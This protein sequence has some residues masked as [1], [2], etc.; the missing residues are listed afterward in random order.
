MKVF[1]FI[2]WLGPMERLLSLL[3]LF[4][5]SRHLL[6]LQVEACDIALR[7]HR[8]E[9]PR[10]GPWSQKTPSSFPFDSIQSHL[11]ELLPVAH[12]IRERPVF[13]RDEVELRALRDAKGRVGF[14]EAH[15]RGRG[16][17]GRGRRRRCSRRGTTA[18]DDEGADVDAGPQPPLEGQHGCKLVRRIVLAASMVDGRERRVYTTRGKERSSENGRK[19]EVRFR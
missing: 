9:R 6:T 8:K 14:G 2:L 10:L 13:R 5:L 11:G 1:I 19:E 3:A 12:C 7:Q 16:L 18:N 4:A 15:L 17:G